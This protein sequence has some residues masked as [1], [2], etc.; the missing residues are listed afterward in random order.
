MIVSSS[1]YIWPNLSVV[2]NSNPKYFTVSDT[3]IG[4]LF[5]EIGRGLLCMRMKVVCNNLDLFILSLQ[6][7]YQ[8][9]SMFK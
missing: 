7:K 9:D 2:S 6:H 3:G 1:E 4:P 8:E 5:R